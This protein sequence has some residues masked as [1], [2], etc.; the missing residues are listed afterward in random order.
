M[1]VKTCGFD[2]K[3][4]NGFKE[5]TLSVFNKYAPIKNKYIRENEAPFMTKKLHKEIMKW[6]KLRNKYLKSKPLTDREKYNIQRN[7]CKKLVRTTK[8]EYFNNLN[9][10]KVTD[11]KTFWRTV[12]P[13]FSNKNSKSDKII[14]NEEGKTF[15]D[16]K[17][18]CR[19]FST[20]F[21]YI[22]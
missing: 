10:K 20:Y 22:F 6:S 19:N 4:I 16:E 7:L 8:K 21:V 1:D 12:A 11:N 2:K 5:T 14:L 17:E 3:D 9:T 18:L 13:T 15:S